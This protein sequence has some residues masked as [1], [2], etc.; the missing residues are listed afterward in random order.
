MRYN[1]KFVFPMFIT[2]VQLDELQ[3]GKTSEAENSIKLLW[4]KEKVAGVMNDLRAGTQGSVEQEAGWFELF[5]KRYW[6]GIW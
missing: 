4:G 1:V 6:R 5:S 2:I 3:Q